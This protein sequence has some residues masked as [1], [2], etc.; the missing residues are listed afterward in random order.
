MYTP[1][2][3]TIFSKTVLQSVK[4]RHSQINKIWR[5]VTS[6][7]DV[8]EDHPGCPVVKN[9]HASSGD[10]G[11]SSLVLEDSTCHKATNPLCRSYWA[12]TLEHTC[13]NYWGPHTATTEAQVPRHPALQS[14]ATATRSLSSVRKS[15][16]HLPQVE[17][18][19]HT[20]QR[21]NPSMNK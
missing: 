18:N 11:W 4:I 12:C 9:S 19:L 14:E 17:K 5:S 16:P 15:S 7:F 20:R 21:P 6:I 2:E 8:Q 13:H 10:I 1:T 3:N